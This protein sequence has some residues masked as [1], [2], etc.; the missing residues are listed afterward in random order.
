MK[1]KL[2]ALLFLFFGIHGLYA[3]E[4]TNNHH[5]SKRVSIQARGE[6]LG[7]ILTRISTAG[8]FYFSYQ[9]TLF[10]TDSLVTVYGQ[11][12]SVR[13]ILD[14]LFHG[15]ID[16]KENAKYVILRASSQQ[17]TIEADN[18]T[19]ADRLYLISGHVTD[20]K[21]GLKIKQASVYEKRLL[22]ST[23]TDDDGYFK[24]RFKGE[25]NEV[26]LTASKEYYR[27]TT[28][29]FLSTIT[30][31]PEYYADSE[32]NNERKRNRKGGPSNNL[33]E[34]LGLGRFF[35]SSKQ[36]IQSLNIPDFFA[37]SP[38]QA[39]LTPGLSSH[40]MMS[41]QVVN[42]GSLNLL[43]GYTAGLDG[44]EAAGIFNISKGNVRYVQVAGCFNLVGGSAQ[45]VQASGLLNSVLGDSKG[46][47]VSGLVNDVRGNT[48]S[49]QAAGI[50]NHVR[51]NASGVQ[52]GGI[53]NIVS[54][55]MN[56][57]QAAGALNIV[58]KSFRGVQ[59]AGL[60]NYAKQMNGVQIGLINIS[61]Q[62]DGYSIGLLNFVKNGYHKIS[63]FTDETINTNISL[64]LGND[65]LYSILMA[66]KNFSD[67]AKIEYLGAGMGHD[68]LLNKR[69]SIS[70]EATAQFLRL[71][72]GDY[73]NLLARGKVNFQFKIFEG[74]SIFAGPVYS[75]YNSS[76]PEG[77]SG[78]GY[79]QHI[80][81]SNAH[82]I[83]SHTKGWL[84]WNAGITIF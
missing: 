31:K 3:Q 12:I 4:T 34:G 74:L 19:T 10:K 15:K 9:G 39:S 43:G 57:F 37:N 16:Y 28:L 73:T 78:A 64:K 35:I 51:E 44:F 79:K 60:L 84:G 69:F 14:R 18:I 33:V 48:K 56:G 27:D 66:G 65:K 45:G 13:E 30:I 46:I 8:G 61:D 75:I 76:A 1:I 38:F 20:I 62:S 83:N 72:N 26:M 63:L 80:A 21:T 36:R 25:Y 24:L 77:S 59:V 11:D 71:K 40:G 42:K 68:I 53:L 29:V 6:K 81:P 17:L 52:A 32:Q 7:D 47:Q 55:D 67:T 58:S 41:S 23:L 54:K 22:Q 49:V 82:T 5:L 70:T 2:T 50:F